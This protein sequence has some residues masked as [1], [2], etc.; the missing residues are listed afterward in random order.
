MQDQQHYYKQEID[1]LENDFRQEIIFDD[2][3]RETAIDVYGP[4]S[5]LYRFKE[6]YNNTL[7]Y[8]GYELDVGKHYDFVKQSYSSSSKK[9]KK[10]NKLMDF[11]KE[12]GVAG[13]L[14]RKLFGKKEEE[15]KGINTYSDGGG[16]VKE[17]KKEVKLDEDISLEEALSTL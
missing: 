12:G 15:E 7:E 10:E 13:F 14:N 6:N 11:V 4:E 16:E 1:R 9:D 5:N 8:G 3:S 17:E 2:M